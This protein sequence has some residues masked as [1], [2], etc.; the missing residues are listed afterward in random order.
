MFL[1]QMMK[2]LNFSSIFYS[3]EFERSDK[4]KNKM[5]SIYQLI[6]EVSDYLLFYFLNW[7]RC[8][9]VVFLGFVHFNTSALLSRPLFC[10]AQATPS[11]QSLQNLGF[12]LT[13]RHLNST[14]SSSLS[15]RKSWKL[16]RMLPCLAVITPTIRMSWQKS[17]FLP[18]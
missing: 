11:F 12:Y 5:S 9:T 1:C 18:K 3:S 8:L 10:H 2:F 14:I 13:Q 17:E 15:L 6:L 16:F 7:L 4:G